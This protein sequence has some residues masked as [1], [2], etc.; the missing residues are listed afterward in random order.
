[1]TRVVGSRRKRVRSPAGRYANYVEVG[2]NAYEIVID[3]SHRYG[4]KRGRVH[5]R[6][7]TSPGYAKAFLETLRT[8]IESYEAT[9]G[10][11]DEPLH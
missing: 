4:G 6:I 10:A 8:S 11:I 2:H 1:M 7:I 3:F 5:T 9:F